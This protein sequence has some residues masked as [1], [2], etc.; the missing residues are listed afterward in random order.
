[1]KESK[2]EIMLLVLIEMQEEKKVGKNNK[3]FEVKN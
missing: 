2:T 1:M 3:N